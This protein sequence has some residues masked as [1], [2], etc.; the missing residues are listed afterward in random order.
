MKNEIFTIDLG[1][2][3]FRVLKY[4]CTTHTILDEF[5]KAVGTA[6]GLRQSG[7]I[8]DMALKRVVDAIKLSQKKMN[9]NPQE[10]VCVTTSAMRQASN[11]QDILRQIKVQTGADF[12]IIDGNK[13]ARITL[14]AIEFAL[15]RHKI[16]SDRF[17]L[18][19]I[20]GG[21]TELI[22]KDDK[23]IYAKSF[24]LG[25]VTLA[26]SKNKEEILEKYQKEIQEFIVPHLSSIASHS[27]IATAGTP[28][29]IAALKV[30]LDYNTYDR[31]KING[32]VVNIYDLD[33]YMQLLINSSSSE[34]N[35]LVGVGRVEF[36]ETGIVI[37]K[38]IFKALQKKESIVFDDGLRE[39]VAIE[40]CLKQELL[41]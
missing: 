39:G 1:S 34:A 29:T 3:S 40:Y 35:K 25:I 28:T 20:G 12:K 17:V 21:S 32:T 23:K 33:K 13:E 2:N 14:L 10:A 6:D 7:K 19:D 37:Y 26:Q 38:T 9:Y 22:I 27:F 8:S 24:E 15:R 11:S 31:E 16:K 5:E 41:Q 36:I 30:G 4:D 18:L